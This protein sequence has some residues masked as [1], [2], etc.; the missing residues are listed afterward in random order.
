MGLNYDSQP[1]TPPSAEEQAI[2]N[3]LQNGMLQL[4]VPDVGNQ[5]YIGSL[6]FVTTE[7]VPPEVMADVL[8]YAGQKF[9]TLDSVQL[10]FFEELQN[11]GPEIQNDLYLTHHV[12]PERR[13]DPPI[14]PGPEIVPDPETETETE[15]ETV[16]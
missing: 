16:D 8:A 13:P 5:G 4:H 3:Q 14:W 10:S 12:R 11:F 1:V 15:T 6:S 7:I 9:G 2:K